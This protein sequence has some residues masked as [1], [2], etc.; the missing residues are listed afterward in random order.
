MAHALTESSTFTASVTV[1]DDGDVRNAASVET[2]FQALA[3]RTKWLTDQRTSDNA[4]LATGLGIMNAAIDAIEALTP[5]IATSLTRAVSIPGAAIVN[6]NTRWALNASGDWEQ[7]G[8]LSSGTLELPLADFP[9]S[10]RI[11]GI[12]YRVA[13]GTGRGGL[14]GGMPVYKL[15]QYDAFTDTTTIISSVTDSS[16]SVGAYEA[17][18]TQAVTGLTHNISATSTY[19]LLIEGEWS[20]NAQIGLVFRGARIT[21]VPVP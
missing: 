8:I 21:I 17:A 2:A 12:S 15:L 18:H 19:S 4:T 9:K 20:T 1:P 10:G 5:G 3:N 7:T 11:S 13:P 14:P 16:A 6:T